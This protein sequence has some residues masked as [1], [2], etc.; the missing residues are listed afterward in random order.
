MTLTGL[1]SAGRERREASKRRTHDVIEVL[2]LGEHEG[3]VRARPSDGDYLDL[4]EL[5][6]VGVYLPF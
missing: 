4:T 3:Q 5:P 1:T 6:S 2:A